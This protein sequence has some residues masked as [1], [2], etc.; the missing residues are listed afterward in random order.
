MSG[1]LLMGRF[2]YAVGQQPEPTKPPRTQSLL[3]L[4]QGFEDRLKPNSNQVTFT[5]SKDAKHPGLNVSV[6]P[7][8]Q[9]FPGLNVKPPKGTWDLATFGHVEAKITNTGKSPILLALR[10]DNEGDFKDNPWNTESFELE[11]GQS[12]SLSTIFGYSYGLKK[13]FPLKPQAVSNVLLFLVKVTEDQSFRID[14]LVAAGPAGEKPPAPPEDFRLKPA[15]RYLFGPGTTLELASQVVAN[16]VQPALAG[17]TGNPVLRIVFPE[18]EE[19][20]SLKVKLPFGCWDLSD[21]LMVQVKLRNMGKLTVTPRVKIDSKGGASEWV[22]ASRPVANGAQAIINVPFFSSKPAELGKPGTGS[23]ITSDAISSVEIQADGANGEKILY[24][25]SIEGF[26]PLPLKL[27][28]W[29]GNKPPATGEWIKTLDEDFD[30]KKLNTSLWSL[31]GEN[32][33]D[34]VTHWSKDN[35]IIDGGFAK[36]RYEKKKGFM[37]DD[38]TRE[39]TNYASGYLES[40]DKWAQRYGYFE[41]RMKLPR[42]P[43][44]WP[45]FWMMPDRGDRTKDRGFRQDTASGGMEFD[46]MEHLTRWGPFRYNISMHYDGYGISHKSLGSDKIYVQPDADGFLTCGLLWLPG[47][48]V[49]YCNGVE[50]LRWVNPRIADVPMAFLFTMPSGGWDNNEVDDRELPADFLIDY[51]RVWQRKD[52]VSPLDGKKPSTASTKGVR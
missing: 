24:V 15:N 48:A 35:L 28:D 43:G 6:H 7:G 20:Q 42:A 23:L 40:F 27:P 51:V 30:G 17:T 33:Y 29:V 44:M 52:L 22:S 25:D 11:P 16:N 18:T 46:I 26:V 4:S 37:N 41:A 47:S 12:G 14:S 2:G 19:P 3:D 10:V 1:I 34:K 49:F 13:G 9:D 8:K 32:Y 50:V 45:A 31:S 5:I 21:F 36:L 39:R 38:P